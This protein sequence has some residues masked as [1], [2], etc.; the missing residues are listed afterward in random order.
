[1]IGVDP[2]IAHAC[3]YKY[4][5]RKKLTEAGIAQPRYAIVHNLVEAQAAL[6][7]IGLPAALKATDPPSFEDLVFTLQSGRVPLPFRLAV[8]AANLEEL[9]LGWHCFLDGVPAREV[10]FGRAAGDSAI[11]RVVMGVE[12]SARPATDDASADPS[13]DPSAGHPSEAA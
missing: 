1:M 11:R 5:T 12:A 3:R 2:A 8:V 6:T 7:D 9:A 10:T 4:E 13:A